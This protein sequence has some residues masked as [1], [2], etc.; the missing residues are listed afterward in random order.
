[1][2]IQGAIEFEIRKFTPINEKVRRVA[3]DGLVMCK[4]SD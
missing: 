2:E 3:L 1:M 4:G